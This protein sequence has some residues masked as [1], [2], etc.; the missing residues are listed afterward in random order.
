VV[1]AYAVSQYGVQPSS[2]NLS[3]ETPSASPEERELPAH[4]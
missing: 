4:S 1:N 3:L 2:L